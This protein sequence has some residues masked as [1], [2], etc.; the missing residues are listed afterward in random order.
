MSNVGRMSNAAGFPRSGPVATREHAAG[1]IGV[2]ELDA[3]DTPVTAQSF[4]RGPR[5]EEPSLLIVE[6]YIPE[7]R[8][9]FFEML[10]ETLG[11]K[12]IRVGVAVGTPRPGDPTR[13]RSARARDGARR[14]GTVDLD[15]GSQADV[16]AAVR[17]RSRLGSDHRRPG[18]ASS[19]E[20]PAAAPAA[21]RATGRALGPRQAVGEAGDPAGAARRASHDDIGSLV[22]RLHATRRGPCR[23]ERLP[24]GSHHGRPEHVR[25]RGARC[26]EKRGLDGGAG[27]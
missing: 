26:A 5:S 25:R 14:A 8:R 22:L 17:T 4:V 9:R 12:S 13:G 7:Y 20:L 18:A 15:R 3:M 19:G 10:E 1:V 6:E 2:P 23:S 24:A 21:A 11:P 27:S 16:P